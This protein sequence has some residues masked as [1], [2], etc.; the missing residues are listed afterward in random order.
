[1]IKNE[2]AF[3]FYR[4][5]LCHTAKNCYFYGRKNKRA[6][7]LL[8]NNLTIDLNKINKTIS[9]GRLMV[10]KR[11]LSNKMSVLRCMYSTERKICYR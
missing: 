2:K 5:V 6:D 1:M 11:S 3:A 10:C 7:L 9:I 4:L 8:S